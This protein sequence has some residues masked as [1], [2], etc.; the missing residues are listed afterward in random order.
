MSYCKPRKLK[1]RA[2]KKLISVKLGALNYGCLT[3]VKELERSLVKAQGTDH[4]QDLLH[5]NKENALL[6][7]RCLQLEDRLKNQ[8]E[9]FSNNMRSLHNLYKK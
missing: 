8:E 3:Q 9:Q 1:L 2:I 5:G 7:E 4:V 6:E